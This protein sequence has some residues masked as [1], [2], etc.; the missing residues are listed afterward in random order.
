MRRRGRSC[1]VVLC[2]VVPPSVPARSRCQFVRSAHPA[3]GVPMLQ[4]DPIITAGPMTIGVD[5]GKS[6]DHS[7]IVVLQT[8]QRDRHPYDSESTP[9]GPLQV[10][11]HVERLATGTSYPAVV[12]RV[13]RVADEAA[14]FGRPTL[15][16]DAS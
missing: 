15:V 5:L 2:R 7:A 12:D 1:P 9:L 8:F 6:R 13:A 16:L 10:I 14:A 4:P 11:R 3:P